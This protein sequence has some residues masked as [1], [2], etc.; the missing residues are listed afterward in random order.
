[1][2]PDGV[3]FNQ[4]HFFLADLKA[5]CQVKHISGG[6]SI[7]GAFDQFCTG[8]FLSSGYGRILVFLKS[9]LAKGNFLLTLFFCIF[10]LFYADFL[11]IYYQKFIFLFF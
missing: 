11:F 3:F 8:L 2:L 10:W 5:V 4:I 9:L 1:V 7:S 6:I